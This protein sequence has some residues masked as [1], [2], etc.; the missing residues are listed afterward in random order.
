MDQN[1]DLGM[2]QRIIASAIQNAST[3]YGRPISVAVCGA[4]SFLIAFAREPGVPVRTIAIAQRKAFTAVWM[5]MAT[6]AFHKR[7][8]REKLRT[9]DFCNEGLI[10]LPGGAPI[11][12]QAGQLLG[13]IGVSGLTPDEDQAIA[14]AIA[15]RWNAL[16]AP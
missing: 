8:R 10:S 11:F 1:I 12:D 2:A 4:D 16:R 13:A 7:L 15:I 5:G 3:E 9:S 14:S 6:S